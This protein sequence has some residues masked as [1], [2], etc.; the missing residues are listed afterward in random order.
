MWQEATLL[1][2]S[3]IECLPSLNK[4][5]QSEYTNHNPIQGVMCP[6]VPLCSSEGWQ[7]TKKTDGTPSWDMVHAL[8]S[9]IGSML[10]L[11]P[12][13]F[14]LNAATFLFL[15]DRLPCKRVSSVAWAYQPVR[16]CPGSLEQMD[17]LYASTLHDLIC[18]QAE[19]LCIYKSGSSTSDCFFLRTE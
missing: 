6:Q 17:L 7:G 8:S 16:V 5:K 4:K 19:L 11:N 9:T 3:D 2:T 1:A 13:F 15:R 12:V 14:K 10:P 18:Y